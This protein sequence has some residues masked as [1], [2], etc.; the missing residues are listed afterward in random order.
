MKFCGC[1]FVVVCLG[2]FCSACTDIALDLRLDSMSFTGYDCLGY[3][4]STKT[5]YVSCSFFWTT[6]DTA[7]CIVLRKNEIFEGNNHIIGLAGISGWEGLIRISDLK[8][9][10]PSSLDD[11]PL[12]RNLHMSD[13]QTSDTGGF[14][15]QSGQRYFIVNSCSSSGV[16]L[17]SLTAGGGGICGSDCSGDISIENCSSTG[18]IEGV[19]AGGIVGR[20]FGIG[21]GTV[22]ITLCHSIGDIVGMQS[23]GICGS[24]AG[25]SNANSGV[26]I[27]HSFSE[28][29]ILGRFSGGI[30]GSVTAAKNGTVAIEQCYSIGEI[31][32]DGSG[33]IIGSATGNPDGFVSIINCYSRGDITAKEEF[34]NAGGISG[35][36]AGVSR[37]ILKITNVYASGAIAFD[38]GGIIGHIHSS[39]IAGAITVNMAVYDTG[40]IVGVNEIKL[41]Q[42]KTSGDLEDI[43][44]KVFCCINGENEEECWDTKTIWQSVDGGFPILLPP[45]APKSSTTA[46]ATPLETVTP[47]STFASTS[48]RLTP[49]GSPL[50]TRSLTQAHS[51][52]PS[53]TLSES[54]TPT[55]SAQTTQ[56]HH[57][58]PSELFPP[59]DASQ[60]LSSQPTNARFP[61]PLASPEPSLSPSWKQRLH[62]HTMNLPVQYPRRSVV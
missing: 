29:A 58:L 14:I 38:G 43:T 41:T 56:T 55:D 60:T 19:S 32:G 62:V 6:S 12:I 5:F 42:G 1:V 45:Q 44:G 49:S 22:I 28:G 35:H 18:K 24:D 39:A 46:T 40:P 21:S 17:G 15:I 8:N 27:T 26:F 2:W 34:G 10:A 61:E 25:H 54:L 31:N 7:T 3:N 33:G 48:D 20:Q 30:C 4:S 53:L 13:G 59:V 37:A 52:S 11:A 16:I 51:P 57:H 23:G 50:A 36:N 47:T 9:E